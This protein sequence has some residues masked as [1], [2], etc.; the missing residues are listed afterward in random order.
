MSV[1]ETLALAPLAATVVG[2]VWWLLACWLGELRRREHARQG[3]TDAV[4]QVP[5]RGRRR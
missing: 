3:G 1:S 2:T 4:V 5:G